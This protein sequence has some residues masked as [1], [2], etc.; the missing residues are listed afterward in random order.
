[1]TARAFALAGIACCLL[2][3]PPAWAGRDSLPADFPLSPVTWGGAGGGTSRADAAGLHR[4]PVIMVPGLRRDHREWTGNHPGNLHPGE[5]GSVYDAFLRAGWR[6]VELWMIDFAREGEEM[7]SLEEATDDLKFFIAS[8][9]RY[10]GAPR[11]QILAHDTGCL[12]ARLALRKYNIAHWVE[13]EAYLAGPFHGASPAPDPLE[14]LRGHP[15]AWILSPGSDLLREITAFGESPLYRDPLSGKD[16]QLRTLTLRNGMPDGDPVFRRLP[17]SPA[18]EGAV[19]DAL[20]GLDHDA[21]RCSPAA[22]ALFIPFL[23]RPA[24]PLTPAADRDGDGFRGAQF[25]GPDCDDGDPRIYPGAPEVRGDGIDQD[26]NG[27]DLSPAGGR[28]GEIPL[29]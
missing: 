28:D 10:T 29:P 13:A 3:P 18:L 7:T 4:I 27:R 17:D 24:T 1:M 20:P 8:V 16:F 12:L 25:G 19:N 14:S 2:I 22:A 26:C 15:N 9:L 5:A 6:P 23:T 21:L 11:V